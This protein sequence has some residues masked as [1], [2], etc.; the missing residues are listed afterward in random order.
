M[1][2]CMSDPIPAERA[3]LAAALEEE[4]AQLRRLDAERVDTKARADALRAQITAMAAA[5]AAGPHPV[6]TSAPAPRSPVEKV[7]LFGRLFRGRDDVYPTRFVSH[8]TGKPGYAPACS[9]K[10]EPGLCLLK[11]GGKCGDC[12]NQA[13][14]PVD[15]AALLLHLQGKHVMGV[16]PMLTDETCWLLA[17]DFDK[18]SWKDDVRAFVETARRRDLPALVER[19]RSGNGAH[20]W[21]FFSEPVPASIAR[22]MGCHLITETMNARHELRMDSYDRLFPSQDT[23]PRGGFGNLIALPLQHQP[24][25]QGNSVFLDDHLNPYP[26]DQQWSVLAAAKRISPAAVER[27]ASEAARTGTIVGVRI[28]EA[29]EDEEEAAP[30]TRA[31]SGPSRARRSACSFRRKVSR[32]RS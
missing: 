6:L 23:M 30:W 20:V 22:K 32:R 31:P 25:Q 18:S 5:P 2:G 8:K 17:V 4:E 21:F 12:T 19:S 28:A 11:K 10:W 26:D 15:Q 27:I 24:R 3:T 16:Y 13:F 1:V 14:R 29:V 9:N 7:G